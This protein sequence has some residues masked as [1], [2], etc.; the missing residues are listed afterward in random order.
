MAVDAVES[1]IGAHAQARPGASKPHNI[2]PKAMI[3]EVRREDNKDMRER[4]E[5]SATT[6]G[7]NRWL[8][9]VNPASH[10]TDFSRFLAYI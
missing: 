8:Q 6:S 1:H 7:H 4:R 10:P 3:V 2:T 5:C 9:D